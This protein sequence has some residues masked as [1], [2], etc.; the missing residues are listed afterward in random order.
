M[1]AVVD[2]ETT[3]GKYNEEGITEI[4]I[5]KFD[6]LKVVDQFISLVNPE[7][8][9]Q[10]FVVNLTGINNEMLRNAP[11]FYEVAK[12][13]VE[14]TEDCVLVAHNAKFDYRILR[15][16]FKRLGFDF[17]RRSLCT[18]ELSKKLIPGQDSYSLGKLVRALGIPLSD[19]HRASGDAQA[20]VKLFKMLLAKDIEKNILKDAVKLEPKRQIDTRL[21][22]ILE[23]LP[24]IT[25][26]YYFH[27]EEGEIIYIGKSQNIKKRV[28]QHFTNEQRKAREMQKEVS[29][30]SFEATGNEL[31]ALLK[32]NQEIKHNKPKFNK[33]LK[34]NIFSHALYYSTDEDG[35]INLKIGRAG[36]K[37]SITTFSS[38]K[39]AQNVLEMWTKTYELCSRLCNLEKG[40]GNCFNYT[41]EKC[42]GAC[43]KSESAE[44]YNERVRALI[45]QHSYKNQHMLVIDR[46]R[47]IDEKSALLV[48]DGEFKGI[49]YFNLN[50]QINNIDI[51]RSIITP[52]KNDRD[53][54]HIIQS[55]LRR[56]SRLKIVPLA[57]AD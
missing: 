45:N 31:A 35:Y 39:R 54:Q 50:H 23:D 44:V 52:M 11:K 22:Y 13:I 42:N 41:I 37:N 49:G 34:K 55:Y 38:L 46:G 2:I 33:V 47:D 1:Y 10:P 28:T 48:E 15:T 43:I 26:V 36:R 25:G 19:R 30:V 5:Y 21:V 3:G 29:S 7:K 17:E 4:A 6:G 16:E 57:P 18:V 9:I 20:T 51:I 8:P 32:E 12:R 40:D 27:N 14:I 56:N 53:A 24:V